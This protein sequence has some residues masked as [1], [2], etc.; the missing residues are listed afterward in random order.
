MRSEKINVA[1]QP[2]VSL[3]S[4]SIF[5]YEALA[6]QGSASVAPVHLFEEAAA[7]GTTA[8][9]ELSVLRCSLTAAMRLL[10]SE[11]LFVNVCPAAM[12]THGFARSIV[13]ELHEHP[14]PLEQIVFELTEQTAFHDVDTAIENI[15]ELRHRGARIALDDVGSGFSHLELFDRIAPSYLKIGRG[16]GSNFEREAW[17]TSVVRNLQQLAR[18]TDCAL[19]L[20]GIE[21]PE[22]ADAARGLGIAFA[23]GYYFRAPRLA[24]DYSRISAMAFSNTSSR[25][26][27]MALTVRGTG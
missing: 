18:E 23:Q 21:S 11:H 1:L 3:A 14:F 27:A 6:R 22:T 8:E 4:G 19:V 25:P 5:G 17:R 16:L 9:L 12:E 2:V 10:T 20:E 7:R 24:D 26:A 15:A 13:A